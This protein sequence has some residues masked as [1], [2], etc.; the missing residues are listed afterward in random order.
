[1]PGSWPP[2]PGLAPCATLISI[3]RHLLRYSAVT[4]KRPEATCLI[5]EFGLS[6]LGRGAEAVRVL[7]ALAGV[8]L[9]ADTVHRDRQ[10]LVRFG[11]ERAQRDAW[12]DQAACGSR[13][14]DSTS[15]IGTGSG[16]VGLKL[17]QVAQA[18]R[19]RL[20]L[21]KAWRYF[22]QVAKDPVSQASAGYVDQAARLPGVM[23]AGAA[24]AVEPA[25][26]QNVGHVLGCLNARLLCSSSTLRGDARVRPMP[27]IREGMPGKIARHQRA[28][29]ADRLEVVAA[30]VGGDRTEMPIFDMTLRRPSIDRPCSG[31][32]SLPG[33]CRGTARGG[34]VR[35]SIPGRDR[36]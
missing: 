20:I 26:R 29:E 6:P 32:R 15:S 8:G 28:A 14:I 3:S 35:R 33:S 17:Q 27:E 34:G 2:S 4:P 18:D 24:I 25:D 7:A 5:A 10:R 36:R 22:F 13:V 16:S 1:M 12:R 31:R 23:L 21:R 11:A 9:G 30:A 19:R